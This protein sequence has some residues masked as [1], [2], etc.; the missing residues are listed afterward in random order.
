M[1]V[2][3]STQDCNIDVMQVAPATKIELPETRLQ[4]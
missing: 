2:V 1:G 3:P 4:T